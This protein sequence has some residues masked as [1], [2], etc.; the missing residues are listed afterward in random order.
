MRSD[1]VNKVLDAMEIMVKADQNN[2]S[3]SP[4][5]S[6][7]IIEQD[8]ENKTKYRIQVENQQRFATAMNGVYKK[9][10]EVY[11]AYPESG[12][13]GVIIGLK[14]REGA[15]A[16]SLITEANYKKLTPNSVMLNPDNNEYIFNEV[17]L[18]QALAPTQDGATRATT[19]LAKFKLNADLEIKESIFYY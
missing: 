8:S 11:V 5:I 2:S 1:L 12:E 16:V 13:I 19:I 9:N 6:A 15:N 14:Y 4:T 17:A 18:Q 3:S 10:D 7:T